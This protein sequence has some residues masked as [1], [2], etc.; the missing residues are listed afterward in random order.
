MERVVTLEISPE[1]DHFAKLVA[2]V[3]FKSFQARS[4]FRNQFECREMQIFRDLSL[5]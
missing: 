5:L 4:V 1:M 2:V 3:G